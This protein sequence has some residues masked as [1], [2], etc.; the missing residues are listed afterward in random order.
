MGD[1]ER[2]CNQGMWV[3]V[4]ALEVCESAWKALGGG[5]RGGGG[6]GGGGGVCS[7]AYTR[8]ARFLPRRR[9]LF[10][11][12]HERE[13]EE[14]GAGDSPVRHVVSY[15]GIRFCE[16][17]ICQA[18][19]RCQ[20]AS[21]FVLILHTPLALLCLRAYMRAREEWCLHS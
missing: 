16:K 15:C 12:S 1:E 2:V 14:E 11:I 5:G 3:R 20:A 6:G 18:R 17:M 19:T 4:L 8:E 13:Y 7:E 21:D 9:S 10:R